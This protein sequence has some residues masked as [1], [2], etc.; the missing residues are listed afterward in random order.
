MFLSSRSLSV[1]NCALKASPSEPRP[2]VCPFLEGMLRSALEPNVDPGSLPDVRLVVRCTG[3]VLRRHNQLAP[4]KC[5]F[6]IQVVGRVTCLR[7]GFC[8]FGQ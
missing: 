6:Y 4:D 7:K 3:A 5:S 1:I 2:Q 8:G